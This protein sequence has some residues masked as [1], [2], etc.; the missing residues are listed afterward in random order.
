MSAQLRAIH[1][2]IDFIEKHL[3]DEIS[4][5]DIAAAADYSL[6]HF[7]R[8]FNQTVHH[9]PYDY[10]MRRRL[11]EAACELLAGDRRILDISLDFC[12]NSHETFSRAF[13]RMFTMQ[14]SQWRA[15]NEISRR[16]LLPGL[17]LA[18]LEHINQDDF[19]RPVLVERDEI[20]LAGWMIRDR[21]NLPQL[22][23]SLEL[24]LKRIPFPEGKRNHYGVSTFPP[25]PEE[26]PFYLAGVE[27]ESSENLPPTLV[28]Q[29]IPAGSYARFIHKDTAAALLFTLDYIYHTWLPKSDLR[30]AHPIEIEYFGKEIP[31]NESRAIFIPVETSK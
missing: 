5:A 23:Q 6:Y 25:I 27:I 14:P 10:L 11:S 30:L 17:T 18:Y 13:K 7:I 3:Q 8:T 1:A 2:A 22:W 26:P 20:L 29:T 4:V 19:L 21:A 28:T 24:T 16:S 12:F 9:S 31:P 15:H